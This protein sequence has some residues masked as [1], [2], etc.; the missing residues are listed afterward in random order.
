MNA[1]FACLGLLLGLY[2]DR[3]A[4]GCR[5]YAAELEATHTTRLHRGFCELRCRLLFIEIERGR[6]KSPDGTEAK[7]A[8]RALQWE[9]AEWTWTEELLHAAFEPLK[10]VF[11]PP[12]RDKGGPAR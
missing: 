5:I 1:M 6:A 9:A 11:P 3:D 12:P 10:I 7:D 8:L 2:M 4:V